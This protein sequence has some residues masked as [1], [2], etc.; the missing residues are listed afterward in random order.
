MKHTNKILREKV[1]KFLDSK[2]SAG[3][4]YGLTI[5]NPTFISGLIKV[6]NEN[7]YH[8]RFEN[9]LKSLDEMLEYLDKKGYS[10]TI[11]GISLS[12]YPSGPCEIGP[13]GWHTKSFDTIDEFIKYM[14]K[15]KWKKDYK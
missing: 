1:Q 12:S 8:K 3:G 13:I 4:L 14:E 5:S 9:A 10:S 11:D 7:S 6:V 2:S 15:K